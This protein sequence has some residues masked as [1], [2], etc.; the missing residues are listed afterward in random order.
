MAPADAKSITRRLFLRNTAAAGAVAATVTTP[1]VAEAIAE[2][3][4]DERIEAA[5]AELQAAL[6][7]KHP[8]WTVQEPTNALQHVKRIENGSSVQGDPYSHAILLYAYSGTHG[9]QT[10]RWYRDYR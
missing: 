4:A 3:S 7:E 9:G 2:R 6:Q 10:A 8:D 1:A 5:I